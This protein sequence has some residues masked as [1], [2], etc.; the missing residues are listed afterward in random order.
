MVRGVGLD[1]PK[2]HKRVVRVHHLARFDTSS[3]VAEQALVSSSGI[4]LR[5]GLGIGLG[6]GLGLGLG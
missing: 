2:D 6:I 1:C 3:N 4:V 5:L